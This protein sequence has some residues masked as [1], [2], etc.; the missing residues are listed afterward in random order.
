MP[1]KSLK[2]KAKGL[3]KKKKPDAKEKKQVLEVRTAQLLGGSEEFYTT[4]DEY[5]NTFEFSYN[6][7]GYVCPDFEG[8][9]MD[10][11]DNYSMYT[12]KSVKEHM[13]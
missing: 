1:K 2:E 4:E 8:G 3:F 6:D 12:T 5:S 13:Q 9:N 10:V 7:T 11:V